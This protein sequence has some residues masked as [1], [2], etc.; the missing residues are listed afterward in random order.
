LRANGKSWLMMAIAG[1]A[2][3]NEGNY[4]P[5]NLLVYC[6]WIR[7]KSMKRIFSLL[8]CSSIICGNTF[9]ADA[10]PE[11]GGPRLGGAVQEAATCPSS[12]EKGEKFTPAIAPVIMA[13]A[14]IAVNFGISAIS[15]YLAQKQSG[16]TGTWV[17]TGVMKADTV[18]CLVL[19]RGE[20]TKE[21][22][23]RSWT[24]RPDSYIGKLEPNKL[25]WLEEW[26][27]FYAE[28]EFSK[29]KDSDALSPILIRPSYVEFF[30]T[31]AR[32][33][34]NGQKNVTIVLAL[35]KVPQNPNSPASEPNNTNGI[36]VIPFALGEMQ[37]GSTTSPRRSGGLTAMV[38]QLE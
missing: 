38:N 4:I 26:P 29:I 14:P 5:I 37:I 8:L 11:Q 36:I 17:A 12:L 27:Y 23:D 18:G 15:N 31:V 24:K 30:R 16:L 3:T 34:G 33:K 6:N 20:I 28:F 13:I 25:P 7:R 19:T 32:E 35:S 9:A 1:N 10:V 2:P 21:K 22:K